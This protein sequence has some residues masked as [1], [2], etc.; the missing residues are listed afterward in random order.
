MDFG[1]FWICYTRHLKEQYPAK[2]ITIAICFRSNRR[3]PG[4][5]VMVVV[6]LLKEMFMMN[7]AFEKIIAIVFYS[8]THTDG[9][10]ENGVER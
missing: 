4:L 2:I 8:T 5:V 1:G 10:G 3:S 9:D 6:S 7:R